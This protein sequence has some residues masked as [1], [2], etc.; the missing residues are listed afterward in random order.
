MK[1]KRIVAYNRRSAR[2]SR[3]AAGGWVGL[4]VL[5]VVAGGVYLAQGGELPGLGASPSAQS[6]APVHT[7]S[8]T[9]ARAALAALE[10]LPVKGKSPKTGYDREG[11][12]G[13]AWSD[14]D[15]NGCDTRN[16]ILERDL[17]Q[18][19]VGSDCH[20]MSGILAEPYTGTTISFTRGPETSPLVQIDHVVALSNA[21]QTGAQKLS[22]AKRVALANDPRNLF[23]VDGPTNSSKGDSDASAWLPP[24]K[25]FRCTYVSAQVEVKRVYD[26]WVTPAERAAITRVLKACS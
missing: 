10:K 11:K 4:F 21:W 17:T 14:V 1:E 8:A 9:Q 25:S 24:S 6:P 18:T 2:R 16:D 15:E 23:A 7:V 12:F 26:L 13:A 19:V 20:V 5:V 3:R 22:Q